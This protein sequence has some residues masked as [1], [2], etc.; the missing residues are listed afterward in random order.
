MNGKKSITSCMM[1][2]MK[3]ANDI[4]NK[5]DSILTNE[6]IEHVYDG[7][8]VIHIPNVNQPEE[9]NKLIKN[10]IDIPSM[11]VLCLLDIVPSKDDIYIRLKRK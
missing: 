2:S 6:N 8:S 3:Y 11:I 1:D 5:V 10:N 9:I 4:M 7:T